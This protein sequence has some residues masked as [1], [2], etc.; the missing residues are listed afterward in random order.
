[1]CYFKI[2]NIFFFWKIINI[3]IGKT[4]KWYENFSW[5]RGSS[6]VRPIGQKMQNIVLTNSSRTL[7]P[8][9]SLSISCRSKKVFKNENNGM[10]VKQRHIFI[11]CLQSDALTLCFEVWLKEC[12][13][14]CWYHISQLLQM[15]CKI[16][17]WKLLKRTEECNVLMA[18]LYSLP[19][20][21]RL[22]FALAV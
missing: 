3:N 21:L 13:G 5:P 11:S 2:I 18:Y 14:Y 4:Q 6:R 1:M 7:R 8:T 19:R 12:I 22:E 10:L 20:K 16:T 17:C 15:Q 9:K